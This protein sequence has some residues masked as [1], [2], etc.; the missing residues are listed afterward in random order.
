M[1]NRLQ[2]PAMAFM[3]K[4]IIQEAEKAGVL[5]IPQGV[6]SIRNISQMVGLLYCLIV[7]PRELWLQK[8]THPL[9]LEIDKIWLL[10]LVKIEIKD[11][12]FESNPSYNLLKH[13]RNAI[14]HARFSIYKDEE[15]IFWDQKN[16]SSPHCFCA[17][18]TVTNLEE[19]LSKVGAIF[20]SYGLDQ[21]DIQQKAFISQVRA[22]LDRNINE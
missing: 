4:Q 17:T 14:S 11:E 12:M 22:I 3:E 21:W 19:F 20:S 2:I 5:N 10:G 6:S 7:V 1:D 13:L 18:F 16:E 15:F 9:F 8:E